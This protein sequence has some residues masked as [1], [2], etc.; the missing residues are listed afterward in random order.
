MS[1]R[2][3]RSSCTSG[4]VAS[5]CPLMICLLLLQEAHHV[6]QC[7]DCVCLMPTQMM[8][9]YHG[10]VVYGHGKARHMPAKP[11]QLLRPASRCFPPIPRCH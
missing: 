11:P 6:L 9:Q 7:T 8:Y 1:C 10:P 4:R 5:A 3:S 2:G